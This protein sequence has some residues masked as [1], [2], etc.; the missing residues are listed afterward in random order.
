MQTALINPKLQ[1]LHQAHPNSSY[2]ALLQSVNDMTT[3]GL[4][5]IT[6]PIALVSPISN[7]TM[8]VCRPNARTSS[9]LS[10]SLDDFL[11]KLDK[12]TSA[13]QRMAKAKTTTH[14]STLQDSSACKKRNLGDMLLVTEDDLEGLQRKKN[15]RNLSPAPQ[16]MQ[17]S[18]LLHSACLTMTPAASIG[19]M[20]SYNELC[21]VSMDGELDN[22]V[23]PK[24]TFR[25]R[26]A[27]AP[28]RRTR[29]VPPSA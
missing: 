9:H 21:V 23:S 28:P 15:P 17:G 16:H 12:V 8:S 24:G 7:T 2:S 19:E 14:V 29:V 11:A 5:S 10:S 22:F 26:L 3:L 18:F 4:L 25:C 13:G 6:A 27:L 20:R 1:N